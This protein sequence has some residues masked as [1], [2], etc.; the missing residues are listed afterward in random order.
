MVTDLT[1][2]RRE[3][4]EKY[5]Q[6]CIENQAALGLSRVEVKFDNYDSVQHVC[7]WLQNT[8]QITATVEPPEDSSKYHFPPRPLETKYT[9]TFNI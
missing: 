2:M 6:C 3:G 7:R 4:A 1:K 9:V 8:Y 5:T